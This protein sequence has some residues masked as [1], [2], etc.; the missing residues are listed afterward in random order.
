MY[1]IVSGYNKRSNRCSIIALERPEH[2][3][4]PTVPAIVKKSSL[5]FFPTQSFSQ[6]FPSA[7]VINGGASF[8][9]QDLCGNVL[10]ISNNFPHALLCRGVLE[11][12]TSCS[13]KG[14]RGPLLANGHADPVTCIDSLMRVHLSAANDIVEFEDIC[15]RSNSTVQSG[16]LCTA[17]TNIVFRR[18]TFANAAVTAVLVSLPGSVNPINVVF[19]SCVFANCATRPLCVQSNGNA[20][21][22]N[23][24][25]YGNAEGGMSSSSGG[26][27][28]AVHCTFRNEICGPAVWGLNSSLNLQY[29]TFTGTEGYSIR[30]ED[31][32][33]ATIKG[34]LFTHGYG[35]RVHGPKRCKLY[36]E[37]CKIVDCTTGIFVVRGKMDVVIIDCYIFCGHRGLVVHFDV[38]GNVDVVNS[39]IL[40][41]TDG[42]AGML[43]KCGPKC[44]L[45]SD[46]R[47]IA[48]L[49]LP[50]IIANLQKDIGSFDL[51]EMRSN[52]KAG[53]GDVLC[54]YCKKVEQKHLRYQKCGRC[55]SV[56]Y[57]S[58]ACQVSL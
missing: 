45:T 28:V 57:C 37:N 58:R 33:C 35:L 5:D 12:T 46:G 49:P 39:A 6:R 27:V 8:T 40:N 11:I 50:K 25:F 30:V 1:V 42:S 4:Q 55:R 38:I 32:G 17:G 20:L 18:C 47:V 3:G 22:L 34:C 54:F 9:G 53:V 23:C 36:I 14:I 16:V 21:L 15:F 52:K 41:A 51:G 31:R 10:D 48:T 24:S 19:E 43:L 56:C 13:V 29:C 44:L 26:S 7:S 2:L